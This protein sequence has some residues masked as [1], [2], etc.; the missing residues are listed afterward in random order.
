MRQVAAMIEVQAEDGIAGVQDGAKNSGVGLR[1]G[2][3]LDVRVFGGEELLGTIAGQ[4]LKYV[5]RVFATT[6]IAFAGI[7]FRV[8]VGINAGRGFHDGFRGEVLT[9][10]QLDA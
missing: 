6:V 4:R 5:G 3:R 10:D 7:A 9:G 8:F 2:M 1:S